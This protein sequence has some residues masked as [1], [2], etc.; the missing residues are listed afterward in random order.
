ML[1]LLT[2]LN[3]SKILYFF[4]FPPYCLNTLETLENKGVYF[5]SFLSQKKKNLKSIFTLSIH[6]HFGFLIHEFMIFSL[7][8]SKTHSPCLLEE[9]RMACLTKA[10]TL[11]FFI[12]IINVNGRLSACFCVQ[13][14]ILRKCDV[15]L[16]NCFISLTLTPCQYIL[17]SFFSS[18]IKIHPYL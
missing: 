17:A 9:I 4:S 11:S 1:Y 6:I 15:L 8:K 10:N 3:G 13:K 16:L 2:P 7:S 14:C 5:C 18:P 12:I